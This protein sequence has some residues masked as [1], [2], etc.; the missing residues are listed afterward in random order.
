[1]MT[2]KKLHRSI[3]ALSLA[4]ALLLI[5]AAV[6]TIKPAT[7][8]IRRSIQIASQ[9]TETHNDQRIRDW[10]FILVLS[11]REKAAETF[12]RQ[13]TSD[14]GR[15]QAYVFIA[16]AVTKAGKTDKAQEAIQKALL[17]AMEIV[18]FR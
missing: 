10:L 5:I 6:W 3:L 14:V 1:M 2:T 16:D 15:F 17:A 9:L 18:S 4:A 13:T 7:D 8:P 12:A 11:G